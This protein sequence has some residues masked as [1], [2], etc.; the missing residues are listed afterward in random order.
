MGNLAFA[1]LAAAGCALAGG[2]WAESLKRR[3]ATLR[4]WQRA[5]T[6]FEAGISLGAHTMDLWLLRAADG[7][8]CRA[9]REALKG[10]AA[11]M[12]DEPLLSLSDAMAEAPPPELT[13][14]DRAAL[15]PLFAGLGGGDEA[16]QR[17][18]LR[19]ASAALSAQIA[20]AEEAERKDRRLA[21]SL[22]AIGGLAV[23]L[24]LV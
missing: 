9:V 20:E 24:F 7:E 4:A 13:A 3:L 16:A 5:V 11:R 2:L 10:A 23:F 8:P 6:R 17:A 15:S 19:A 18:L 14:G 1:L 21:L 22:G 12:R